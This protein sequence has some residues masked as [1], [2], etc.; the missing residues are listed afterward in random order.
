[1][2]IDTGSGGRRRGRPAE[3]RRGARAAAPRAQTLV[4]WSLY[5][6]GWVVVLLPALI[7]L[8]GAHTPRTLPSAALPETF[9]GASALS[10]TSQLIAT[11]PDRGPGT[12]GDARAAAWVAQQLR[13]TGISDVHTDRFTAQ[14]CERSQDLAR[15]RR[16]DR[17][18]RQPRGDPADGPPRRAVSRPVS[19][20]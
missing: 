3:A 18:R 6:I 2:A 13:L 7:V 10:Y 1:M 17:A 20:R 4:N 15:E 19:G 8:V 12:P 16:G 11:A 5:R 9:D 14:R